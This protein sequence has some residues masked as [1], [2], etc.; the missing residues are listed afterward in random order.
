MA[1]YPFNVLDQLG[2]TYETEGKRIYVKSADL[3]KVAD[4]F[5][6]R[7]YGNVTGF[8]IHGGFW[9]KCEGENE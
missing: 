7:L 1:D 6:F 9:I 8:S 5:S 3:K 4:Y 2:V